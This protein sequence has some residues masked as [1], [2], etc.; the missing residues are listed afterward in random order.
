M[1]QAFFY[2]NNHI[3]VHIYI[4]YSVHYADSTLKILLLEVDLK[5]RSIFMCGIST[6]IEHRIVLLWSVQCVLFHFIRSCVAMTT[7]CNI[8]T[9]VITLRHRLEFVYLLFWSWEAYLW[10]NRREIKSHIHTSPD[11]TCTAV[12]RVW[13]IS[14]TQSK[15]FL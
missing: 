11:F 3:W 4:V 2:C 5:R 14:T 10:T 13:G 8:A 1:F 12:K 9:S 7:D 15:V 6:F